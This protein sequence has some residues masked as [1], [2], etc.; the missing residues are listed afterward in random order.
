[1]PPHLLGAVKFSTAP[2]PSVDYNGD[3]ILVRAASGAPGTFGLRIKKPDDDRSSGFS[4]ASE[5]NL[6]D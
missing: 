4:Q 5:P 2:L 1:M 3:Y 6:P